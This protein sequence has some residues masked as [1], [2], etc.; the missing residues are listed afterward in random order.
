MNSSASHERG[1][2][3]DV[4]I[5]TYRSGADIGPC[6]RTLASATKNMA[7]R[8]LI[9][10]NASEDDTLVQIDAVKK[11]GDF[12]LLL[13]KNQYN[14]G[15]TRAVNQ[16]AAFARADYILF[17]NP[18]VRLEEDTLSALVR[19]LQQRPEVGIVAPQLR[20][21][22]GTIQPSCR[23]IPRRRD[24]LYSSLGLAAIFPHSA[25]FN[26]WKMGDFDHRH[27]REVA[28]PQGAFLL[29]RRQVLETTGLW[30]EGFPMFFSDVDWCARVLAQGYRILFEPSVF[31]THGKGRSVYRRRPEMIVT[32][33]R[34]FIRY[35]WKYGSSPRWWLPNAAVTV[36]LLLS[37][38]IRFAL[39]RS[40]FK[41]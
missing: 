23:R 38:A 31:A 36:L 32:S 13:I 11:R 16:A 26:G 15:F 4:I 24:V 18:D 14:A 1:S 21:S 34:S 8:V 37:G 30:D 17:L 12:S 39:S 10:D 6:L 35:F 29:C 19:I 9:V 28:Q 33:H 3:L 20:N 22:D 25:E 7:V 27:T 5:V 41:V 40:G 2:S